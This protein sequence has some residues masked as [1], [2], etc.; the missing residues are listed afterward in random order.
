MMR[1][2]KGSASKR[3]RELDISLNAIPKGINVSR[4]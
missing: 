3:A 2:P 1:K 4:E